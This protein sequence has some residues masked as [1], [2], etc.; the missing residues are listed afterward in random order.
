M[1][2]RSSILTSLTIVLSVGLSHA[3]ATLIGDMV[4]LVHNDGGTPFGPFIEQVQA[5]PTEFFPSAPNQPFTV[6][7]ES[8]IITI[9]AGG[10]VSSVNFGGTI[11]LLELTSLDWVGDPSAI[12]EGITVTVDNVFNSPMAAFDLGRVTFGDHFL[13]VDVAGTT[14]GDGFVAPVGTLTVELQTSHSM[15]EPL[16][17]AMGVLGL[18]ILT[19]S[20]RRRRAG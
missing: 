15:P 6:N 9:Q 14:W 10:P 13:T 17:S 18:G 3:H 8:S 12:I 1:I 7:L 19:H 20:L 2:K 4:T 11:N 5:G 16:T